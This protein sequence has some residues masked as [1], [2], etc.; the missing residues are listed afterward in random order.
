MDDAAIIAGPYG[1]P[2]EIGSKFK[3]EL[4]YV[5]F[6]TWPVLFIYSPLWYTNF[7]ITLTFSRYSDDKLRIMK[8]YKN[9]MFVHVRVDGAK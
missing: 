6:I 3:L 7:D 8:G 1:L 5:L 2:V 4:L 9:T